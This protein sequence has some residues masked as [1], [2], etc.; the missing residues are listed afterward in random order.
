VRIVLDAMGGD[1]APQVEIEGAI[2]AVKQNK[3][4]T[5]ILVG[6]KDI[7]E[8][9][10]LYTLLPDKYKRRLEIVNATEVVSMSDAPAEAYKKKPD[11]S[12]I[13]AAKLIRAG[14]ADALVSAGNTGAVVV[15]T[16]LTIGRIKGVLR[17]AICTPFPSQKGHIALLD[18]GANVDCKPA[19]LVQFAVMG[20]LYSKYILGIEKPIIGM[21]SVGEEEE[22]GNDLTYA[23][24]ELMAKTNLNSK[25]NVEGRDVV[26]GSVDVVV[27]DGFVGNVILKL[28]EGIGAFVFRFLKDQVKKNPF[29][30]LG[31]L[32]M[33]GAFKELKKKVNPDEYGGA[34]LL[35]IKKPVIIS[36]GSA[37]PMGIKNGINSAATF[38]EKQIN[39]EIE[40]N[41][42]KL[43]GEK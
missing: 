4:I 2:Q 32:I 7:I 17:P 13:V 10:I 40:E 27:C 9:S 21:I 42:K 3:N 33:S 39:E 24:N 8:K 16:L 35:G 43:G 37:S 5:V 12:I 11:S 1:N 18:A 6:K 34:P 38:I 19:H 20:E 28:A 31:A 29:I 15:T 26:N 23:T 41:I 22:K 14:K 30:F 36:H 25:G